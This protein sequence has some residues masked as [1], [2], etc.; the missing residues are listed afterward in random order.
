M[1]NNIKEII[2]SILEN[3]GAEKNVNI[4]GETSLRRDL[5]FDSLDL[6]VLTVKIEDEYDVDIFEDGI[7]DTVAEIIAKIK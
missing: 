2:A 5:E 3:K 6:A 4:S 7:I 1:E